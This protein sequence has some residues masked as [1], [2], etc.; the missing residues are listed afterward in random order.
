MGTRTASA[1]VKVDFR[2]AVKNLLGQADD[3]ASAAI[4]E[5]LNL[6]F[7]SGDGEGKIKRLWAWRDKSILA[8]VI[9]DVDLFDFAGTDIGT[10]DGKDHVGQAAGFDEVVGLVLIVHSGRVTFGTPGTGHGWQIPFSTGVA[11]VVDLH[12][13]ASTPGLFVLINGASPAYAVADADGLIG[14]IIRLQAILATAVV[15]LLI[16]GRKT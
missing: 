7:A 1:T 10:G 9:V 4:N 11:Q 15:S 5:T 16:I 13:G 8:G 12:A 14:H 2:G 3:Y 6:V